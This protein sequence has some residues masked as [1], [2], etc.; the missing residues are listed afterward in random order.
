MSSI[1]TQTQTRNQLITT[2][3]VSKLAL[4]SND[5]VEGTYTDSGS[6]STISEGTVMG[7]VA[8][9][10]KLVLLDPTA[11]DGSQTPVGIVYLGLNS[12]IT[13]AASADQTLTLINKGRVAENKLVFD[14]GVTIEDL[15]TADVMDR[16]VRDYLNA[17]GIILEGGTELTEYDNL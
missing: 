8:A 1:T 7:K 13:V 3:D 12:S 5:F 11:S 4:G 10:G 16:S 2:S 15:I 14:T 6:G 9:T 17:M